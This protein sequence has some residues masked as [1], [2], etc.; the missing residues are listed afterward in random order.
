[1][2]AL[3]RTLLIATLLVGLV[4]PRAGA[5]LAVLTPGVEWFVI[6]TGDRMVTLAVD[7]DGA[8]VEAELIEPAPCIAAPAPAGDAAPEGWRRL[9][10]MVPLTDLS[11]PAP[12]RGRDPLLDPY[13]PRGPPRR[14]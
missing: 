2:A 11:G 3:L 9:A 12:P 10:R 6:C 4:F 7:A 1:M 14:L 8:P 5:A 13:P